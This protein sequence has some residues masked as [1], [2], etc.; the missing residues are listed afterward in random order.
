MSHSNNKVSISII[1]YTNVVED[2]REITNEVNV[3]ENR[4]RMTND[5]LNERRMK[6]C[7]INYAKRFKLKNTKNYDRKLTRFL[8][9]CNQKIDYSSSIQNTLRVL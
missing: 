5:Q 6:M 8:C 2:A 4:V 1:E 9:T 7:Y 3:S